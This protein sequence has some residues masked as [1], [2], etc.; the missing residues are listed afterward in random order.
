MES[1]ELRGEN[2]FK[3]EQRN[4][5]LNIEYK[6]AE[7]EDGTFALPK[8]SGAFNLSGRSLRR[9]LLRN[10]EPGGSAIVAEP[11]QTPSLTRAGGGGKSLVE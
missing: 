8:G 1:K 11:S 2:L 6:L 4:S 3:F 7:F 5:K 9:P 10:L